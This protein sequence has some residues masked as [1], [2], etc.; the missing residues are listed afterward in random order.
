LT[1]D[2]SPLDSRGGRYFGDCIDLAKYCLFSENNLSQQDYHSLQKG[3][4]Y[5]IKLKTYPVS[6][7]VVRENKNQKNCNA[8][9]SF[10]YIRIAKVASM[11]GSSGRLFYAYV[12][13]QYGPFKAVYLRCVVDI[14]LV[15][16]DGF[17]FD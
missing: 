17:S 10:M 12:P 16:I 14:S 7:M 2:C 8:H 4:L 15:V 3:D 6:K 1:K 13:R 5:V 11:H 9:K